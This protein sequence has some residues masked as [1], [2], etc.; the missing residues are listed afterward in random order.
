MNTI[1]IRL[2]D[3]FSVSY[4]SPLPSHGSASHA[5]H[6]V[7]E[8]WSPAGDQLTLA[9]SGI[10]ARDYFLNISDARQIL[11]VDGGELLK[12]DLFPSRLRVHFPDGPPN[13]FV[14]STVT[15]RFT[16]KH[17]GGKKSKP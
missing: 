15:I 8:E 16:P 2:S 9:L 10:A 3:D 11:S 7:S 6:I 13:T 4:D 14:N 12:T 1:R 5:L 17:S